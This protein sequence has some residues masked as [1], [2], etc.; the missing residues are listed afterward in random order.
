MSNPNYKLKGCINFYSFQLMPPPTKKRR[1]TH[2]HII[3]LLESVVPTVQEN[4][5]EKFFSENYQPGEGEGKTLF[6]IFH[7][8]FVCII[9]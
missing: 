9:N 7:M 5:F 2:K 1:L 3:K 4:Q 6:L 8:D